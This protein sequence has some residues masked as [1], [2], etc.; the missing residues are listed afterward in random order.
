MTLLH[1]FRSDFQ[2]V[3]TH[4]AFIENEVADSGIQTIKE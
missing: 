1:Q 2:R 3:M 4:I